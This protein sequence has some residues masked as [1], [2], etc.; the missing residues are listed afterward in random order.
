MDICESLIQLQYHG[1]THNDI[2]FRNTIK[3]KD[4][5]KLIDFDVARMVNFSVDLGGFAEPEQ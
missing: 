1:I 4:R 5:Y 3:V 2:T